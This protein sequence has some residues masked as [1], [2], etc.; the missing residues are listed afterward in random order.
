MRGPLQAPPGTSC[1]LRVPNIYFLS[2]FQ[3]EN[4]IL[5]S[6]LLSPLP[7]PLKCPILPGSTRLGDSSHGPRRPLAASAGV[8][9][10]LHPPLYCHRMHP[11]PLLHLC[12][13][14]LPRRFQLQ[15]QIR[16]Q[17]PGWG[18]SCAAGWHSSRSWGEGWT[19]SSQ[20]PSPC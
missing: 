5:Y 16:G 11:H 18:S 20:C 7:P 3:N 1:P 8:P 6:S 4:F 15:L 19:N 12:W 10:S 9:L 14:P 17:Q 13:H 2:L